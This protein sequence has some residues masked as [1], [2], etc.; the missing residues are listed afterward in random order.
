MIAD[1]TSAD[2]ANTAVLVTGASGFI[3]LHC[4]LQLLEQGYRVR[5]TVRSKGRADEVRAA[6]AANVDAGIAERLELVEADLTRAE[7]RSGR[8][9]ATRGLDFF[10]GGGVFRTSRR[11]RARVYG[12]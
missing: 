8:R 9:G 5:G 1:P 3:G 10:S 6:M 7:G 4:V 2:R 12:G 11:Q